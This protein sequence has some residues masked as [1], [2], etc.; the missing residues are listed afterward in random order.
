[1]KSV[2]HTVIIYHRRVM[3][4]FTSLR[5]YAIFS[6]TFMCVDECEKGLEGLF[7]LSMRRYAWVKWG[8][9]TH[10]YIYVCVCV[11]GA[12]VC[13]Q[14]VYLRDYIYRF[15]KLVS[16]SRCAWIQNC[17]VSNLYS[18]ACKRALCEQM[19]KVLDSRRNIESWTMHFRTCEIGVT[20]Y[21]YYPLPSRIL[22]LNYF[23]LSLNH[24]IFRHVR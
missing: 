10:P 22:E 3:S 21:R 15:R 2:L 11:G 4:F 20:F 13:V 1:M 6:S 7:V 23:K 14:E 5:C 18:E 12:C 19:R 17:L 9:H 16:I 24:R 8:L